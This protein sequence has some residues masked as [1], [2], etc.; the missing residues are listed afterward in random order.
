MMKKYGESG[1]P[2]WI[3]IS[4]VKCIEGL[5]LTKIEKD[6]DWMHA[7]IHD[8]HFEANAILSK[9]QA[10]NVQLREGLTL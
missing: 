5:S 9:I 1:S 6:I 8:D 3:P 10:K 7:K 4:A 2:W